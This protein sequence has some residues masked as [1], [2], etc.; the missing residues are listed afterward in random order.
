MSDKE[1]NY[2]IDFLRLL[3]MFMIVML[4]IIDY[5]GCISSASGNVI[6]Y[7]IANIILVAVYPCV[8]CFALISGYV[9]VFR[10]ATI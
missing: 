4:H 7:L 1:R 2:G 10:G 6:N 5:G 9:A 3:S 8:N